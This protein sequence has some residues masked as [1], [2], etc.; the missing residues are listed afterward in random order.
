M[1]VSSELVNIWGP[2]TDITSNTDGID[3]IFNNMHEYDAPISIGTLGVIR[4]LQQRVRCGKKLR[5]TRILHR[6][7]RPLHTLRTLITITIHPY[8]L[9]W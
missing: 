9:E 4:D 1:N 7:S 2:D 6:K 3:Q 8:Y 5:L